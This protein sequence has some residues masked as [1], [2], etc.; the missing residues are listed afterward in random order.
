MDSAKDRFET[1]PNAVQS[2]PAPGLANHSKLRQ[3]SIV[4]RQAPFNALL[5]RVNS[6]SSARSD[7]AAQP[8]LCSDA[9]LL[10]RG[11]IPHERR[12]QGIWK[13]RTGNS[14]SHPSCN[15]YCGKTTPKASMMSQFGKRLSNW[16]INISA[17][18]EHCPFTPLTTEAKS[19]R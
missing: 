5:E 11:S 8:A 17:A 2:L 13:T 18:A 10:G 16:D 1:P 19:S 9:I 7:S 15:Q 3:R 6:A 4:L 14:S 12:E